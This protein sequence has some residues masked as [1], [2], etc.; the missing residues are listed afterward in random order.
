MLPIA[1]QLYTLRNLQ[2]P[3]D[4]VLAEVAA[5]GYT[6]VELIGTHNLS[7]PEMKALL[8]KHG[9][10]VA[11]SHAPITALE[12]DLDTVLAFH[13]AI[14]NT[15]LIVP[16]L[17]PEDRGTTGAAWAQLGKRLSAIGKRCKAAGIK[18]M[19]HN[20]AFEMEVIEGKL[21]IDWL[22]E[23]AD[24]SDLGFEID[25]AWVQRGGQN[26]VALLQKYAGR[27]QRIHCKDLAPEGENQ[28][29]MGFA[30]VGHGVLDWAALLPAAK[31]AGAEWYIVEHDLP[32]EPLV[33]I[34]RSFEFL[35]SKL[36]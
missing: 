26:G 9:L 22:L 4:E 21:A 6:G 20:H 30:D 12:N 25:L 1:V 18:L 19:Y 36:G 34:R 5:I 15:V 8:A 35:K 28:D 14:G 7:A 10:Q 33:S 2:M 23:G 31:A 3:F 24:A 16:F 29:Q 13:K 27:V 11:S 17:A 32:K